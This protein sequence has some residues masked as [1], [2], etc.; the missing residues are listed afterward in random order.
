MIA[1]NDV[2]RIYT[3]KSIL[4]RNGSY[5]YNIILCIYIKI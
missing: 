2:I 4:C 5:Y 1:M 3:L